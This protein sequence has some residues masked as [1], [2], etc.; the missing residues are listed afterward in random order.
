MEHLVRSCFKSGG[1]VYARSAL[2]IAR[3]YGFDRV[4]RLASN[5][6][7]LPP[8][9]KAIERAKE[10]LHTSNR[11]P[12]ETTG[13][14]IE[15]L[16]KTHGDYCFVTGV[17]MD[18]VIETTARTLVGPGDPV[19]ISSPTF[20]FYH[21]AV[22]ALSGKTVLS[23]REPDYSVNPEA[24]IRDAK[25]AKLAF[26]C[27]PNN[28]TGN[29]TPPDV[30]DQIAGE[31]HGV[32]FLDNAYVEF[33]PYEYRHLLDTHPNLIIGRTF[34]K[35][36]SL[37]GLR[38]GYAF[39]PEW[40][41]P[42]YHR[43]ATPHALNRVSA[44]GAA[45]ALADPIHL[46]QT[47]AHTEKWRDFLM[48]SCRYPHTESHSNFVMFDVAPMTGE[49][50]TELLAQRGVIVRS[51]SSFTGL[52]NHYIRVSIGEAWENERFVKEINAL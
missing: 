17:G 46:E 10:A 36:Y 50:V 27:S 45:G 38:V 51:C 6:N 42:C 52:S 33:S 39:V 8:S 16:R 35:A 48:Q 18:G 7:P 34:S 37:A 28:P 43:A 29:A 20:S 30:I 24:F 22:T 25:D 26:L 32:L 3:S 40:F 4:A 13:N 44:E 23:P 5:E 12:D 21:L 47:L 9:Q 49:E 14:L 1:Y 41:G 31:I 2:E 15:A 11:Y 19:V